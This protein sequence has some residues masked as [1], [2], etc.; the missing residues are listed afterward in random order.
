MMTDFLASHDYQDGDADSFKCIP[1]AKL[2]EY[3][4]QSA[5][6][7]LLYCKIK[8]TF[9]IITY[10]KKKKGLLVTYRTLNNFKAFSPNYL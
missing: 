6:L 4:P 1:I 9:K 3:N 8:H 7:Y 5:P 10:K 2:R